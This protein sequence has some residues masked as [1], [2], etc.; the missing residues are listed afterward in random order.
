MDTLVISGIIQHILFSSPDGDFTIL[1]M[2]PDDDYNI[3]ND[4]G[5][6]SVV[7]E[8]PDTPKV[9][10][11][12]EFQGYWQ[13]NPR[14][15]MQFRIVGYRR[16]EKSA[17]HVPRVGTTEVK[18]DKLAGTILR[19]TFYNEDNGWG[20]I[21]IAPFDD[22]DYPD[23]AIFYDGSIAVV[24]VMPELVE[25]ES[26][27]FTG[28]WVNNEQYGKQFKCDGVIPISPKNKQG[29]I[30]YISDTV[31]G[32]GDVTATKI[33][34]H[35]GD[36]TLDVLDNN[37]ERIYDVPGLKT[38]LAENLME[39]WSSSR[40]VRQIMIHLQS[41]GI[42]T[43]IA[44]KIYDEY[45]HETLSIV[46]N[47]P[48]QLADDVHG[49]G[50]KKADQIAQGMGIPLDAPARLK[51]GLVYTLS[52][53]ANDGHTYAPQE[54]LL[55]Q[56][57]E[58]LGVDTDDE[59][60]TLQLQE[61]VLADKLLTETFH[62]GTDEQ[63]VAVYLPG[64]YYAEVSSATK[65]RIMANSPS[66]IITHIKT[67][68]DWDGYLEDLAEENDVDLSDEQQGA[69]TGAL[70]S[71]ISVLT[72]GPGTGKT[73][74]LRMVIN[75]LDLEGYEYKLASPTGRAAKRLSEATEKPAS[76]IHR[77][78]GFNPQFGGFDYDED[79]P[80]EADVVII[81][82]AS[83]IDLLLFNSLLKALTPGCH[84][85]LVGDIDQLPSVGAGNVLNDV[86]DSGIAHVT[87]LSQI[88]RQDDSSHIVSN[89]HRINQGTMPYTDNES[90]D[91]FFFNMSEPE[92]AADTI[93]ELVAERLEKKLGDY[94][95]IH[96]VQVIAPMYRGAIGVNRL[97]EMLQE[98]LN[99]GGRKAEKKFGKKVFR[100]GDKVMQTKNNYEKE[101]FNGDIGFIHAI[102]DDENSIEVVMDGRFVLYDYSD[103]DEHLIHA[104]CISTHRSQGS[105]YPVVVMP[106]MTQHYMMLQRNLI[107]T[108]I[109]R[110][111]TMAVLVGTRKAIKLA[112]DNNKVSERYSGLL[113]R[114]QMGNPNQQFQQ[115]L[116]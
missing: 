81:D 7:G 91:F 110:A 24:G 71:K 37:P 67:T 83:M 11:A 26:A 16:V 36:D 18:G 103:A 75:A 17:A 53:M 42:T 84:L 74:T 4:D 34:N 72:G 45:Q 46:Q 47:D 113:P 58:I 38:K 48:Y 8:M 30:R 52:Q 15:G 100:V 1:K 76:T 9:G 90:S 88:F 14:Y 25:G 33:Y 86:I 23:E 73:T 43:K 99:P 51:A 44:K 115:Q 54:V 97:N 20:V 10:D 39:A 94:N 57:R 63:F 61:Q 104:Y 78:L 27:E 114:L 21:K 70:F 22:A 31:F 80:L 98:R 49:I 12:V 85:M 106:I 62:Y 82:E 3:Q 2:I 95:P 29:I 105:E 68:P 35:F 69:V 50:F 56:A 93:V 102:D 60:L 79:E 89:A 77:L 28:K 41:Y 92:E 101:V 111:K 32:I 65:L 96:D 5:T 13:E 109:T 112:V 87:R 19:I 40:S 59:K 66:P 6:T 55:E 64:F 107:Y 116:F 108:A